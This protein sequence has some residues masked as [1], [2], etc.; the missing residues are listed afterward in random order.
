MLELFPHVSFTF[1]KP[2]LF[3]FKAAFSYVAVQ[4]FKMDAL[5]KLHPSGSS[6]FSLECTNCTAKQVIIFYCFKTKM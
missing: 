6:C 5:F 3:L 4:F 1:L 2:H